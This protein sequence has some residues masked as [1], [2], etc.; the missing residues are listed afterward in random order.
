MPFVVD[1]S[2][3]AKWFL[4]EPHQD[5][6]KK[7]LRDFVNQDVELMAPELIVG[8]VGSTLWKRSTLI[9]DIS[10]EHAREA[11]TC[12]LALGRPL[13]SSSSVAARALSIA[14]QEHH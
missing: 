11:Y 4:P 14:I 9:R 12:F 1:A 8:E 2:V 7:L 10:V 5:K 13:H 3:A 6:A